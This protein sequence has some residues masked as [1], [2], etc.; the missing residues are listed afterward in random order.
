MVANRHFLCSLLSIG[1]VFVV[2]Q[3][4][5]NI[6]GEVN[7]HYGNSTFHFWKRAAKTGGS[8]AFIPQWN[9]LQAAS[10]LS[11]RG[12]GGRFQCCAERAERRPCRDQQADF[13]PRNSHRH[14]TVYPRTGRVSSDGRGQAGL[15]GN[16][17]TICL[18]G[19]FQRPD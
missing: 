18:G 4:L 7:K 13:G 17:R 9:G 1:H 8:T 14:A 10:G 6:T 11:G 16:H 5:L 15:S 19:H 12:G 2:D 3:S